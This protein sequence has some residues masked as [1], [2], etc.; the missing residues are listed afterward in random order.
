MERIEK[1]NNVSLMILA[2]T[3]LT[4]GLIYTQSILIP[5]FMALCIYLTLVPLINLLSD[6]TKLPYLLSIILVVALS[7]FIISFITF[8]MINSIEN[9]IKGAGTYQQK[10]IEAT[11]FTIDWLNGKGIQVDKNAVISQINKFPLMDTLK[12]VSGGAFSI[13]S[14]IALIAIF[15]LF[16]FAGKSKSSESK[17]QLIQEIQAKI[18]KYILAKTMISLAT[19]ALVGIVLISFQIDLALMFILLTFLLNFIPNIGSI[20]AIILPLPIVL[21]QYGMGSEF[22]LVATLTGLIQLVIGNIIEPK[23]LG[24][25]M[26]LHPIT[27]LLFLMFWGLVWGIPGMFLAVPITAI[28]KITLAKIEPTKPLAD[29]LSGKL[30]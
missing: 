16:M 22:L 29:L 5:F 2:T 19:G 30:G 3:A 10:I 9:F 7:L 26:D 13:L 4:F 15:V 28:L 25:S 1:I 21:L 18:S 27:I 12:K 14:N 23:V 24:E 6:K 11:N 17:S 20:I 8:L